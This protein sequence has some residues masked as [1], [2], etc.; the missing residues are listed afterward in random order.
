M[1]ELAG[2]LCIVCGVVSAELSTVIHEMPESV[3]Y[4]VSISAWTPNAR[5][6]TATEEKGSNRG[7][8]GRVFLVSLVPSKVPSDSSCSPLQ[9][10][11]SALHERSQVAA[12]VG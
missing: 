6:P 7:Q 2:F 11:L 4:A 5:S 12:S 8:P 10:V 3:L 9:K 1:K